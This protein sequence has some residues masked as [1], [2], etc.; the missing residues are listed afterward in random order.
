MI[1]P[2]LSVLVECKVEY[3]KYLVSILHHNKFSF[4]RNLQ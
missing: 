2:G 4:F 1:N 3:T